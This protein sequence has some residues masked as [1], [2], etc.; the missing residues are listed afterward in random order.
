MISIFEN[1]TIFFAFLLYKLVRTVQPLSVVTT[2]CLTVLTSVLTSDELTSVLTVSL[3]Q[4]FLSDVTVDSNR[5]SVTLQ[6]H[7]HLDTI[8]IS[9]DK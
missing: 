8:S 1:S 7:V 4:Q 6:C 9:K 3:A 5:L 2:Q